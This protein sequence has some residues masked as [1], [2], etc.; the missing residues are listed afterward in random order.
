MMNLP[1]THPSEKAEDRWRYEL[2]D[3]AKANQHELAALS[4]ALWLEN[5]HNDSAIGIDLEPTPHFVYCPKSAILKLNE[6]VSNRL[7][8]IVGVVE[9]FNPE[10]EVL[11]V[12]LNKGQIKLIEFETQPPPPECFDRVDMDVDAL[13]E[14]LE[15]RLKETMEF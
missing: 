9:G 8:E 3:F 10:K 1:G 4:W 14:R 11:L 2:A 5:E 6:N 15:N 13:L 12:G 7:Q